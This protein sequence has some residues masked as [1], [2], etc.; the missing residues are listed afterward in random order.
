ATQLPALDSPLREAY[1]TEAEWYVALDA[2]CQA[3]VEW[4]E[5]HP[6][7][8]RDAYHRACARRIELDAARPQL[9]KAFTVAVGCNGRAQ[10][11]PKKFLWALREAESWRFKPERPDPLDALVDDKPIVRLKAQGKSEEAAALDASTQRLTAQ[12]A[13]WP[14]AV[15]QRR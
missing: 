1:A 6:D 5:T 10:P 7:D 13:S 14:A 8:W 3:W 12:R 4:M 11:S 2:Y 15:Q 9:R